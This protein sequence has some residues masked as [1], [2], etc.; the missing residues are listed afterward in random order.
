MRINKTESM[1]TAGRSLPKSCSLP[2]AKKPRPPNSWAQS[3]RALIDE[4]VD[5]LLGMTRQRIG[6]RGF[7]QMANCKIWRDRPAVRIDFVFVNAHHSIGIRALLL[8][9][10]MRRNRH[11]FRGW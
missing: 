2:S 4:T 10:A 6:G 3:F 11:G 8:S 5:R 9:A 1:R 7:S